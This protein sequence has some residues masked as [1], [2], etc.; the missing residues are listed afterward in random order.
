MKRVFLKKIYIKNFG[1]IIEDEVLFEPFTYFIGRNN[2]GKS[3][4]LRAVEVF[5]A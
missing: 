3:H 5:L 1:P 4:Y 2:A